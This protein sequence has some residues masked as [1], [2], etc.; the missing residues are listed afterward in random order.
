MSSGNVTDDMWI[1]Y[2]KNQVPPEPD[3]NLDLPWE[4]G[5]LF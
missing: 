2:I 1:E 5:E 4:S 3:D